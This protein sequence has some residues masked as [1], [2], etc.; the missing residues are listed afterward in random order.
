MCK[1]GDVA[2]SSAFHDPPSKDC[3]QPNSMKTRALQ[4]FDKKH[5]HFFYALSNCQSKDL[6]TDVTPLRRSQCAAKY[7]N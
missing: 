3:R 1:K 7:T 6:F 5:H 2:F 4:N